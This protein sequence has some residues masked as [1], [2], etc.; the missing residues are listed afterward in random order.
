MENYGNKNFQPSH[1]KHIMNRL[2]SIRGNKQRIL[3]T[4]RELKESAKEGE[5]NLNLIFF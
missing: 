5:V 4:L 2:E 3:S 1:Q